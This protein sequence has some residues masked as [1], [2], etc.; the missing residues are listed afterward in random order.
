MP[1]RLYSPVAGIV[2]MPKAKADNRKRAYYSPEIRAEVQAEYESG[3]HSVR[4]LPS[5]Q[6]YKI[7]TATVGKWIAKYG[8]AKGRSEKE[9]QDRTHEKML[10]TFARLGM[11]KDE[12]V[13][14]TIE[15]I[16]AGADVVERALSMMSAASDDGELPITPEI[17][18][19]LKSYG[20]HLGARAK[21][22]ELYAKFTGTFAATSIDVKG[23]VTTTPSEPTPDLSKLSDKEL[24]TYIEI[25]TKAC[26]GANGR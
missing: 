8:W 7:S 12:V 16:H 20:T 2:H 14:R 23:D 19:S 25:R 18:D 4:S 15:G 3:Q 9:I 6:K 1:P 5:R 21:F 24:R 17:L 26:A 11:P 10:D 22:V 13:R